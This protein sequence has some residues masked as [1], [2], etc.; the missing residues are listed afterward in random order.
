LY[1]IALVGSGSERI[2]NLRYGETVLAEQV[3][4]ELA[5]LRLRYKA[6]DAETSNLLEWPI[7]RQEIIETVDN[8]SERFRF[9]AAVAAFGQQLRGGKYLEQFS[10]DEIL[11]L[12]RG[13]DRFG[14]RA[15]FVNLV[16]LA[17]SLRVEQ[18]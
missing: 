5:F 9:S 1:E 13:D 2:E 11:S 16:S 3:G 15:E 10:F 18:N 8:T 4:N 17:Q 14:Y 12:A 7:M 6:P